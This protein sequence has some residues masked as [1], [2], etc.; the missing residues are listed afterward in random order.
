MTSLA[1][2]IPGNGSSVTPSQAQT[3]YWRLILAQAICSGL[4]GGLAF[5]PAIANV[6]VYFRR[7]RVLAMSVN[8]CGSSTGA[9]VFPAIVQ[10]LKPRIGFPWAVRVVG[11]VAL[12]LSGIGWQ[13]F[14]DAP[15]VVFT[16]GSFLV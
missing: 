6:G 4:G 10:Y 11:F 12:L 5:V 2:T 1:A 14:W 8:A 3:I 13:A 16:T 15:F 7:R 9:I